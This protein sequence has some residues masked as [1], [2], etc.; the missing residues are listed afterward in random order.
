MFTE[1]ACPKKKYLVEQTSLSRFT[2]SRRTNDLSDDIK[3]T[4]REKKTPCAAFSLGLDESTDIRN[5]VQLV[6][7]TKAVIVGFDVEEI[8][9][10]A[11][12][13]FT[14][15]EQDICGHV[16]WVGKKFEQ[17]T[18]RLCGFTTDSTPSKT[19]R[20]NELTKKFIEAVGARDVVVSRYIIHQ[21]NLC[22]NVLTFAEAM[23][24]VIQCVNDI[25]ERGSIQ[26]FLEFLDCDY[27]DVVYFSLVRWLS[28]AATVKRLWNLRKEIK[29]FMV[30]KHQNVALLCDENW[31]NDLA[32][33]TEI[34]QHLS[35]LNFKRQEKRQLV[36]KLFEL[37]CAFDKKL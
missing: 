10:M 28:R 11:S 12:L 34:T 7:F 18:A 19:G 25:R 22:T 20:T 29:V 5:T 9:D 21:E 1:Y 32:F 36:N 17:N 23:K 2:D 30:N 33:L 3:E 37:I 13:F 35:E 4:L 6:T 16:T 8:I 14:F 31:L 27:P 15:T 26:T 24:N